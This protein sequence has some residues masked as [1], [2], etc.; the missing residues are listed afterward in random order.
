MLRR[1]AAA[2]LS[3]AGTLLIA[4]TANA[5]DGTGVGTPDCKGAPQW[6]QVCAQDGHQSTG[7]QA[8]G[9]GKPESTGASSG[10]SPSPK[11]TYTKLDPQPPDSNLAVQEGKKQGGEGAVYRVLCPETG[12]IGVVWI[13]DAEQAPAQPAIDPEVLAQRAVDSMELVGPKVASPRPAG[14]YVVGMPMW[15]W[16]DQT[17]T[18]YGPATATATAGAVTVTATAKVSSISWEMGDGQGPVVCQGPGTRYQ[19]ALGKAESPDCGH[20]YTRASADQAGHRYRVTA[21]ST[22][23]ITWQAQGAVTEEGQWTETRTSDQTIAVRE[24][25]ALVTS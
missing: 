4:P 19:P 25:Q 14:T 10:S 8:T 3:L 17:P 5:R 24:A 2:A 22:W 7:N 9:G 23:T 13:P 18:T 6:V 16:V 15:M 11:C 1:T 12:R 20:L 21:T